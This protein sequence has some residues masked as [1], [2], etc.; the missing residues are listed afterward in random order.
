[1]HK[2]KV[3]D[4]IVNN[5]IASNYSRTSK[6]NNAVMKVL[7]NLHEKRISVEIISG[8]FGVGN[9]YVVHSRYFELKERPSPEQIAESNFWNAVME[10]I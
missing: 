6:R 1:M 7:E 5:S 8:R 3:G 4:I 9:A 10:N 2:F